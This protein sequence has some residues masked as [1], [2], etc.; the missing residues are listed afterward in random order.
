MMRRALMLAVLSLT[1]MAAVVL[2]AGA[3]AP[4]PVVTVTGVAVNDSSVKIYWQPVPSAAD[5]RVYDLGAPNDVK[6]AGQQYMIPGHDCPGYA[7]FFHFV[8]QADGVTPVYPYQ[9]AFGAT[10]GP[11]VI[12]GPATSLEW[13]Q[14]GDNQPHVLVVEAVDALGP[15][16]QTS[17]YTGAGNTPLA[18]GGMLG[19][20]KGHTA[21]GRISTNGQ[22]PFTANPRAIAVSQPFVVQAAD[23]NVIPSGN[24]ATQAF[25]DTFDD[26]EGPSLRQL[27][28][29]DAGQTMSYTLNAGTPLEWLIEYAQANNRDSMPFIASNH[30][31]DMLFDGITPGQTAPTHTT[32]GSMAMSPAR[33]VDISGGRILHLTMEVDAH[34]SF[35]RWLAFDL[36]PASDPLTGWN[37][38]GAP[39]NKSD[40][41]IFL[42]TKDG[43]CTLQVFT[44]PIA[45]DQPSPAGENIWPCGNDQMYN[46]NDFDING[47]GHLDDR[48]RLDLFI[49]KSH[50]ALFEDNRLI[51]Q[52]DIPAG[53]FDWADLPIKVYYAHYLYHSDADISELLTSTINSAPLCYPLNSYWFNDP[54]NGRTACSQNY[55]PGYGFPYSDE[56]HWDNMGFE[57]LPS[58]AAPA[59]DYSPLLAL[60]KTPAVVAPMLGGAAPPPLPTVVVASTAVPATTSTPAPSTPV[61]TTAPTPAPGATPAPVCQQY[62][63]LDSAPAF[64]DCGG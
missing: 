15:V 44:G 2:V 51:T 22:G 59:S 63:F 56:R 5:Y 9:I 47:I 8:S 17:L 1:L 35:R 53:T 27:A 12:T 11:Q 54:I 60:V 43:L 26:A 49:S 24:S 37:P 13:N 7:C 19:S 38:F 64:K 20:N 46:P 30:F 40:K 39:V 50:A 41:A 58:A 52:A 3:A 14:I 45:A 55:H 18:S 42:E 61:P 32:Y 57:V 31:M 48:S 25:F 33:T 34:Q 62:V 36:A 6:Y 28:R 29:D 23:T 21:D 10:G 4:L 16:P